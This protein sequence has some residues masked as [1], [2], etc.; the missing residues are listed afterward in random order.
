MKYLKDHKPNCDNPNCDCGWNLRWTDFSTP[1]KTITIS[2]LAPLVAYAIS[3]YIMIMLDIEFDIPSQDTVEIYES[4]WRVFFGYFYF[5]L[6][7]VSL[8]ISIYITEKKEGTK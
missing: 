3:E 7:I 6:I 2:A 5:P 1:Q 8:A 4:V